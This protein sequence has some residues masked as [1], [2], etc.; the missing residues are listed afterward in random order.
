MDV[1]VRI[2]GI[3]V[4]RCSQDATVATGVNFV[5]NSSIR[6]INEGTLCTNGK[7]AWMP[8]IVK[9]NF[10]PDW[11]DTPAFQMDNFLLGP[12]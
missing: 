8:G 1:R 3:M 2:G 12:F 11:V 4:N 10:D 5:T 7:I 9:A 6:K